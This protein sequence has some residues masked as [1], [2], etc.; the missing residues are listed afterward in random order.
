MDEQLHEL[1]DDL[2]QTLIHKLRR[3]S[4]QLEFRIRNRVKYASLTSRER[5]VLKLIAKDYNN[6]QMAKEL[7]ISRYTVEQH[8]KNIHRKLETKTLSQ[9]IQFALAY[10]LI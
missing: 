7:Y 6:P 10:D 4:S 9:L 1:A 3:I 2:D 5:E 8:R